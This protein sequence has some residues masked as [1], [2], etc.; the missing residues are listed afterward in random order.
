MSETL[1]ASESQDSSQQ[2]LMVDEDARVQ[3]TVPATLSEQDYEAIAAA[4]METERGRWFLDEYARRNRQ[5]DTQTVLTALERLEE[6]ID[7]AKPAAASED[8]SVALISHNVIDLAEAITQVKREVQEL[9]G[10]DQNSDHFNTATEEL[11]AIVAQTETATGEILEAAEKVQEVLWVLR[12][13][14]ANETQCDIIESKIIDI[15]TACSFQDLTGQRSNKVV[16]LVSYV[17]KRV[18]TMMDILG[19][20][21]P[22]EADN[23]ASPDTSTTI[24]AHQEDDE[25]SDAHLLN[26]PAMEGQGNEQGDVDALF[27][28]E[29]DTFENASDGVDELIDNEVEAEREAAELME[30]LAQI[31]SED[32]PQSAD[33]FTNDTVIEITDA[34]ILLD[35]DEE[36]VAQASLRSSNSM[37]QVDDNRAADVFEVEP[38][39]FD[40]PDMAE[41]LEQ[42]RA[43]NESLANPENGVLADLPDTFA[44][45]DVSGDMFDNE[46]ADAPSESVLAPSSDEMAA[47]DQ[48]AGSNDTFADLGQDIFDVDMVGESLGDEPGNDAAEE[49]ALD[50]AIAELSQGVD[51]RDGSADDAPDQAAYLQDSDSVE[52]LADLPAQDTDR[53]AVPYTD[54]ERIALFS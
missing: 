19:L 25:R 3:T 32:E 4:V 11:E 47:S 50:Q 15:Y 20:S 13:E 53:P 39:D 27:A 46:P 41:Q 37:A 29:P 12:E 40:G 6:K 18:S 42:S 24:A 28:T 21:A 38:L 30:G 52:E 33:I 14:G 36:A 43:R 8:T 34:E 1:T 17:E 16:R 7:E 49:A 51:E 44:L 22:S 5:S 23:A 2:A 48:M 31:H 54:E 26:G 10:K 35:S 45:E 9:G